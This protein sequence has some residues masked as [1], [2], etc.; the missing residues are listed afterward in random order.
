M[1]MGTLEGFPDPPALG[2]DRQSPS[3]PDAI[4]S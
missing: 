3:A 4:G 1:K 2:A